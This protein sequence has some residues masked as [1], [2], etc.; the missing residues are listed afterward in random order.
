MTSAAALRLGLALSN[1]VPVA[2]TVA[3]AVQAEE[4][5]LAE[6]WVPESSHG[7]GAF[8]VAAQVV[9]ATRTVDVGIGI[10]NPFWRHP[11]VIAMEAAALDEV[12][13]GRIRLGLGA[14]LWTLRALGEADA[15]TERPLSAMREAFAIVTGLLRGTAGVDGEIFPARA[16]G[17]L[18]F[19][20]LRRDLPVY[21]GAVNARMLRVSG[22]LVD[23][24]ELGAITSPGY[25][26]WAWRQI[27]AGAEAAG[28]DPAGIDLASPVLISVGHDEREARRATRP[29]LA[30]YLHR[31][32]SVVISESGADP[33]QVQR[34]QDAVRRAGVAAGAEA[35][36]DELIDIFA[37]AGTPD[38][39]VERL[40]DWVA[41][42]LRGVLAWHVL[43]PDQPEAVR[44]LGRVVAPALAAAGV[45][46]GVR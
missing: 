24:V 20:L 32:E 42:G 39:V 18:D 44:L 14:A 27:V 34:V 13:G 25:T 33:E 19:D 41:A 45:T 26:R 43:G 5:G 2:R 3:L 31:V 22:A 35:V 37:A 29:V 10:V 17:R 11:S 28:R 36:T 12:S 8:T 4:S 23:G 40:T 1:E 7:R 30:Y 38:Q 15:R 9:A 6:V 16:D 46:G 21:S